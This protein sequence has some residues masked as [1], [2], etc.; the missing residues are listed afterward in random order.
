[1]KTLMLLIGL[2]AST[3]ALSYVCTNTGR[4]FNF[5]FYNRE[6][7]TGTRCYQFLY[8]PLKATSSKYYGVGCV[9]KNFMFL[10]LAIRNNMKPYSWM[11]SQ[12]P[13]GVAWECRSLMVDP[14]NNSFELSCTNRYDLEEDDAL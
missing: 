13:F 3:Q 5:T 10:K 4:D 8:T 14:P 7:M 2:I 6:I 1:M 9:E 11:C 12:K